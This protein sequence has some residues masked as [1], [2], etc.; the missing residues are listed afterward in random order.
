MHP[1]MHCK[2]YFV[3]AGS[4]FSGRATELQTVG[5]LR[6]MK[7]VVPGHVQ[8]RVTP[9]EYRAFK[10]FADEA[11]WS[12]NEAGH[13]ALSLVGRADKDSAEVSA[14]LRPYIKKLAT[15]LSTGDALAIE[16]VCKIIDCLE[17]PK[18]GH[19]AR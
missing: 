2:Y 13:Y 5:V 18:P 1:C 12:L 14:E 17:R 8:I 11:G 9:E 6:K 7:D 3:I 10:K 4:F 16:A 15:V 19:R